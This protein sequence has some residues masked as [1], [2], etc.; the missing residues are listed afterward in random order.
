VSIDHDHLLR[1]IEEEVRVR[2][3]SGDFPPGLER[4]LDLIFARFA[5]ASTSGD[6][7]E[8]V[9]AAADRSSFVNVDVPTASRIPAVSYV[10]RVLRKLMSWYLRYLAQQVSAFSSSAVAALRVLGRRVDALEAASPSADPRVRHEGRHVGLTV[11]PKP[12]LNVIESHVSD[13]NGSR[14]LVAEAGDGV[15]LRRLLDAGIDAYGLDPAGTIGVAGGARMDVRPEET[16]DHLRNV[17]DG[18]LGG[19]VLCGAV[20]R[21]PVGAQLELA[22]RAADVLADGGRLVIVSASPSAWSRGLDPVDADLAPGRPLHAETWVH[23]LTSRGFTDLC[24]TDGPVA[25]TLERV[26]GGEADALNANLARIEEA[27]FGPVAVAL[28]ATRSR[29]PLS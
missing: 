2:R 1:E 14:V 19:L 15:V 20:D 13:V 7:F 6:D 25:T 18:A 26:G 21:L 3:A 28:T 29:G 22:D 9:L 8:G 11:D 4:D 17:A 23:L 27:L 24:R 5:P 12:F 10:K 16:L